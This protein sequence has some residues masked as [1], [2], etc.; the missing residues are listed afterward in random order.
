M[1]Y[2]VFTRT[3]VRV[4]S[5]TISI[6]PDGRMVLNAAASRI[7]SASGVKYVVL[8]W[9][10]ASRRMAVKA[11]AKGDKNGY[12][13]SLSHG[14]SLRAKAFTRHIGWTA[15]RRELLP[16]TWN[17]KDLMLEVSLPLRCLGS[18]GLSKKA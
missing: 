8:L 1:A 3:A 10:K 14:A 12:A 16:A 11:T 7:L 6:V 4:E 13:V 9:D 15:T 17:E 18:K 2:E 5:P